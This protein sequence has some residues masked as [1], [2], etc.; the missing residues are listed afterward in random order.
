M[1]PPMSLLRVCRFWVHPPADRAAYIGSDGRVHRLWVRA[2]A[3]AQAMRRC[4]QDWARRFPV[5]E[6][7]E[8]VVAWADDEHDEVEL[9]RALNFTEIPVEDRDMNW[10]MPNR[11]RPP[12]AFWYEF[13]VPLS[14]LQLYRIRQEG[15]RELYNTRYGD[16][17][18]VDQARAAKIADSLSAYSRY[19]V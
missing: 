16:S 19:F 10:H 7:I 8:C 1:H 15:L 6:P 4:R 3:L 12:H 2:C 13:D 18:S 5:F 11:P 17:H 9:Y 14:E